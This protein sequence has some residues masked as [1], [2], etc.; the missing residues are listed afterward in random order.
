MK[1]VEL[2]LIIK[3]PIDFSRWN[4]ILKFDHENFEI[5][6]IQ[7]N[8]GLTRWNGYFDSG[9][10]ENFLK[11]NREILIIK[12]QKN[13]LRR[14]SYKGLCH[15]TINEKKILRTKISRPGIQGTLGPTNAFWFWSCRDRDFKILIILVRFE[16]FLGQLVL[17][18]RSVQMTVILFSLVDGKQFAANFILEEW[19]NI[20]SK[21]LWAGPK[22]T[23]R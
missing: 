22:M 18:R 6:G 20:S 16:K 3:C 19:Q 17:V 21:S 15:V 23:N 12:I 13:G 2:D 4:F 1:L 10:K 14:K 8:W 9:N 11:T 7:N 5:F